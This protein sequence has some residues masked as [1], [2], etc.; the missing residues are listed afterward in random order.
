MRKIGTK[1]QEAKKQKRN[2]IIIGILL[3]SVLLLSTLGF[4]F[5]S[6]DTDTEEF[7]K[8][9]YQGIEFLKYNSAWVSNTNPP[10]VLSNKPNEVPQ[11]IFSLDKIEKYSNLPLYLSLEE[12]TSAFFLS[13][14]FGSFSQRM[15]RACYNESCEEDFPVKNCDSRIIVLSIGEE[16]ISQ[17]GGCVF[18]SGNKENLSRMVD[19]FILEL[20]DLK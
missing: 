20:F 3:T 16:N 12:N 11:E 4:S 19:S 15:Q 10:I 14:N 8:V 17:E 18:I 9:I 7:D 2:A 5:G 13:E 6:R 1:E